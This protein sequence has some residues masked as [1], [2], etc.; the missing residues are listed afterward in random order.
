MDGIGKGIGDAM[1]LFACMA[2]LA[3]P[4]AFAAVVAVP[5]MF[6]GSIL[7]AKVAIGS[8]V[9]IGVAALIWVIRQA[10]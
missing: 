1:V 9:V 6:F 7:A 10:D 3:V 8:G 4:I 5:L 2:A